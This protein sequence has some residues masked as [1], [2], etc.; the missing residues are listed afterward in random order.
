MKIL[1]TADPELPVPPKLYGGIERIIDLLVTG[2]QSLGHTVGLVAHHQSTVKVDR[3]FPW[4]GRQSQSK[5]DTLQ[6]M[7]TLWSAVREFQPDVVHSFSRIFYMLPILRSPILKIMSYQRKPSDRTV[8]LASQIAG[9]SLIFT[10]CSDHICQI[11]RKAGGTWQTIYNCVDLEKYTFQANVNPDA[12]LV[13]LSR[14]ERIKGAH[15]AIAIAQKTGKRLIIA[16][17]HSDT[18]EEGKYWREEVEPHLDN[19]QIEYIGTVN[20][21][22]KNNLLGQ[23]LAMVVPIEWEEPFGI[24]FA[25][26]LACGT[27]VIS[28]PRGAL[29]EII[30][31]EIDGYLI[32][33]IDE[34][35]LAVHNI[36]K[37]NRHNCRQRVENKFSNSII[38]KQYEQIYK[39]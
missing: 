29:P 16:G 30:R 14:I 22:Q 4:K 23:A 36:S 32:E 7:F 11:G 21:E 15:T 13:F 28:C 35:C 3:L 33:T 27:P 10:G 6:N 20:D 8:K 9:D 39:M 34:A 5:L 38:T 12:P 25:E 31:Q 24:V 26:A 19:R 17:N 18:G 2:L 37:I 1:I